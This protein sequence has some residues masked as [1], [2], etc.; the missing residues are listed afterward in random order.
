MEPQPRTVLGSISKNRRFNCELT[1]Y[2]RGQVIG[3]E[4]QGLSQRKIG[5]QLSVSRGAVTSTLAGQKSRPQGESKPRPGQPLKYSMRDDRKMLRCCRLQPKLTFDARRAF[6]DTKMSNSYIKTLCRASGLSHWRAKKR[7][8]LL[9]VHAKLRYDWCHV[10]AHWTAKKWAEY[11]W[12][13]E[14]S[15]ERGTGQQQV[16]VFGHPRDKYK[17]NMVETYQCGKDIK[18]MVWGMFWGGG[19]SSLVI[20]ERDFESKKF[21]YSA[22]SYISVLD[23]QVTQHWAPNRYFMQDNAPIHT[24]RKVQDWFK[25]QRVWCSDWPPY[26]PDLNPI[27]NV[28]YALKALAL[29]RHPEVMTN[30]SQSEEAITELEEAL[31]ETWEHLPE[32]LFESLIESMPR[33]IQ[34]CL[35]AQGWH[36]KY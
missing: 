22:N 8:E 17:P 10:R 30:R 27:E 11:I 32:S 6:C 25:E 28:W 9:E 33:R 31:K 20:M 13:D 23:D 12:S 24:A 21:G 7:P 16:W 19:R 18:V 34:A 36:T 26:S 14:C 29:K 5:A 3:L 15:V 1:P 4:A 2:Q 35:D